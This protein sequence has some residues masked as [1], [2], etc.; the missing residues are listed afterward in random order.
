[1]ANME[2]RYKFEPSVETVT[3]RPTSNDLASALTPTN[4]SHHFPTKHNR[5]SNFDPETVASDARHTCVVL[6]PKLPDLFTTFLEHKRKRGSKYEK[7]LYATS[8]TFDWK[9]LA[10]RLIE[11]RPLAFLSPNDSTILRDGR[12]LDDACAEWD[13]NGSDEQH[14]N[15][16]LT[17]EEYL[18][19]DE[20]M[21]SSLLG[22]SGPTH[23]INTGG[24]RN[25]GEIEPNIP[26]QSRGV[27]VGLVGARFERIDRMDFVHILPP[28]R[29]AKQHPELSAIFEDF[30]GGRNPNK[31]FFD[32]KIYK[33]RMRITVETLLMEASERT[34]EFYIANEHVTVQPKAHVHVVGLGL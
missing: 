26:H 8:E 23:F 12:S 2:E 6:H 24:R 25:K 20:I 10:T 16:T 30:F 19:Y 13:R 27:I 18:S 33:A 15:R 7:N 4:F 22:A 32:E 29:K 34:F 31:P 21:L 3:S 9:T 1:M 11:K 28:V 14:L 17:L 5:I